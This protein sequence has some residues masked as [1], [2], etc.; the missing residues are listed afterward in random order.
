MVEAGAVAHD[1]ETDLERGVSHEEASRRLTSD[2]PNELIR[3]RPVPTWRKILGHF[4]DPLIYLLI[5]AVVVSLVVWLVEGA[6]GW[7]V[8]AVVIAVIVVANAVLGYVQQARAERA[9]EAL[10]QADGG[11]GHRRAGRSHAA[12]SCRRRGRGRPPR[13]R[14]GGHGRG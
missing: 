1:L 7:P 8:D 3:T 9:V 13:D 10:Q 5:V 6:E 12:G 11:H 2:G 4:Q 14:G